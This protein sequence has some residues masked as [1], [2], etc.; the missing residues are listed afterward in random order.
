LPKTNLTFSNF[1]APIILRIYYYI[2]ILIIN[3]NNNN[4]ILLL[5][6]FYYISL[7]MRGK[8][9]PIL[10]GALVG[11]GLGL[12]DN[13]IIQSVNNILILLSMI[14]SDNV[15]NNEIRSRIRILLT[16]CIIILS[17]NPNPNQT[18]APRKIGG[19][20]PLIDKVY[21]INYYYNNIILLI[22]IIIEIIIIIYIN[23]PQQEECTT[24]TNNNNKETK[25]NNNILE[26]IFCT[27]EAM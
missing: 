5:Y 27:F 1:S 11:L 13:M 3:N 4:N 15:K 25:K 19:F 18:N 2:I 21:I 20:F 14:N 8:K 7:S 16:L 23:T 9:A 6:K 10:R 24:T 22:I 12:Q 26:Y 17:C